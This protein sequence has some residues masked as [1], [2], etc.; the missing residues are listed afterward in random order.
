MKR[1]VLTGLAV[2]VAISGVVGAF[3]VPSVTVDPCRV[4]DGVL[5]GCT[6]LPLTESHIW[7]R[8]TLVVGAALLAGV[9]LLVAR[10]RQ[11]SRHSSGRRGDTTAIG[12]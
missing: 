5:P 3:A 7:L 10:R 1:G 12:A 9:L 8:V 2:V 11:S 4:R 6:L